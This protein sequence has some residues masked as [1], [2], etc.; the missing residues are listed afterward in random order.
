M[1]IK[2]KYLKS[3]EYVDPIIGKTC[4]HLIN[5]ETGETVPFFSEYLKLRAA[6]GSKAN[7]VAAMANDLKAFLSY[8]FVAS[9][10][11]SDNLGFEATPL[12]EIIY[13]YP[14]FLVLAKNS[15]SLLARRTAEILDATP[16]SENSKNR[17]LSSVQGFIRESAN[18]Q[19]KMNELS[20]LGIINTE[21]PP[22]IF[23][24][25]LRGKRLASKRERQILLHN[26][27]LAG[28][29]S[30]GA[31][32]VESSMFKIKGIHKGYGLSVDKAFPLQYILETINNATSHRDRALWALLVGTGIRV[33][34]AFNIL[35][36][37]VNG[38]SETVK[39]VNPATRPG[40]Y[41]L[42]G[43]NNLL[44]SLKFKGRTTEET[45]FLQPFKDI[46]FTSLK[47]YL[48]KERT[49]TNHAV[50]FVNLSNRGRGRPLYLAKNANTHNRPFKIASRAAEVSGYTIHSLRHLYGV[51]ALNFFPS[52]GGFGL[53][54]Q[55]VQLMMGHASIR[56]TEQYAIQDSEIVKKKI[57]MFNNS[58]LN[59]RLTWEG[60][61]MAA[62]DLGL[63]SGGIS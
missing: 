47:A 42:Q 23:G 13:G 22:H 50:L 20:A 17:M 48:D 21:K 11:L 38:Y 34:E 32:F 2:N 7:S 14:Q 59:N 15:S 58:V 36:E 4:Y 43:S 39:I 31:L 37:D 12:S 46:F 44:E 28:C 18:Y 29:I 30:G 35:I 53:P 55:T 51:Y 52:N 62:K 5:L 33:S 54:I 25:E 27:F 63:P 49:Q 56:S 9:E 57:S 41:P 10:V 16:C 60:T 26:S 61:S 45:Y 6:S 3:V 1:A 8:L 40:K 19:S 24:E